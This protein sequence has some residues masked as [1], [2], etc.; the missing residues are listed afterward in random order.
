MT[1]Y[2]LKTERLTMRP[3]CVEDADALWPH[4]SNPEIPRDMAWEAH[5]EFAETIAF[6]KRAEEGLELGHTV[7]WAVLLN[8]RIA[9]L[10][11]LIAIKRQ[12]RAITYDRA[13]LAYWLAPEFQRKGIMTEAGIAAIRFSFEKLGLNKLVVS[14]HVGNVASEKL[15]KKLGFRW[16]CREN[17]SFCKWGNWIDCEHYEMLSSE[18]QDANA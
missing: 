17:R 10:F 4:L 8:E 3:V 2:D 14:H 7:H 6:L 15:I 1:E 16:M 5:Q 12:H 9:G 18:W 11:S 13:E